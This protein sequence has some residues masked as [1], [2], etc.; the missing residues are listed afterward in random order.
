M[1]LSAVNDDSLKHGA[2]EFCIPFLEIDLPIGIAEYL[3][4]GSRERSEVLYV[5]QYATFVPAINFRVAEYGLQLRL[6]ELVERSFHVDQSGR[7]CH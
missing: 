5:R 1:M 6:H 3:L 7:E 4:R 2:H